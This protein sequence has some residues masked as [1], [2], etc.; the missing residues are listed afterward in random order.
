MDKLGCGYISFTALLDL[1]G[2]CGP[3][4]VLI[5]CCGVMSPMKTRSLMGV[6]FWLCVLWMAL[7]FSTCFDNSD[8]QSCYERLV[9]GIS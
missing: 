1:S 7:L 8:V 6:R 3:L 9:S 5:V 4:R 2:G